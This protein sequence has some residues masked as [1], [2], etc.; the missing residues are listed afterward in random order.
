MENLQVTLEKSNSSDVKAPQ[1]VVDAIITLTKAGLLNWKDAKGYSDTSTKVGFDLYETEGQP[2]LNHDFDPD[3]EDKGGFLMHVTKKQRMAILKTI[4]AE[5]SAG[6]K[7][8]AKAG[9]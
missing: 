5:R 1:E 8:I 3:D 4:E 9:R 7:R 6:I 2:I